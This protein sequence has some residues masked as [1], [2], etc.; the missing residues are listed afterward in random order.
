MQCTAPKYAWPDENGRYVFYQDSR[1]ELGRETVVPCGQCIA[2]R[3]RHAETWVSRGKAELRLH[4]A[5]CFTTLTYRPELRPATRD[6]W[7]RDGRLYLLRM[8]EHFGPGH[9]YFGVMERGDMGGAP[10]F[11]FIEF[12]HDYRQ[13][14][15]VIGSSK[16]HPIYRSELLER[17]WPHGHVMVGGVTPESISYVARYATKKL[18]GASSR[19]VVV[20]GQRFWPDKDGVLSPLP[21]AELFCSRRP[22]IGSAFVDQFGSDLI[23]GLRGVGGKRLPTPR[24]WLRRL[25]ATQ[26]D[27]FEAVQS[28]AELSI[29]R[30]LLEESAERCA[31]RDE[32]ARARLSLKGERR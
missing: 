6:A 18:S 25:K 12:G 24:A 32:V 4:A 21:P 14:G 20:E 13:G 15:E 26:P 11:H 10:H 16:G 5:S 19:G 3:V 8:Q 2:C 30:N 9:R 22:A 17:L 1:R 31:V 7:R 23:G 27:V 29:K 28:A